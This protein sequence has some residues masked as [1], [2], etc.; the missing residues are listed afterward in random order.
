MKKRIVSIVVVAAIIA[1]FFS[2]GCSDSANLKK[3]TDLSVLCPKEARYEKTELT[4]LNGY[5][6]EYNDEYVTVFKKSETSENN[7]KTV[8]VTR[9]KAYNAVTNEI[10]DLPE[11]KVSEGDVTFIDYDVY[12]YSYAGVGD[13]NGNK[14]GAVA[15]TA[16][17]V[18]SEKGNTYSEKTFYLFDALGTLKTEFSADEY[19]KEVVY[20][21]GIT[22]NCGEMYFIVC[23]RAFRPTPNGALV[24]FSEYDSRI[25]VPQDVCY[26]AGIA[27]KYADN[28]IIVYNDDY[29]VKS[30]YNLPDTAVHSFVRFLSDG[31]A[32][33]QYFTIVGAESNDYDFV[34]DGVKYKMTTG[35]LRLD[36]NVFNKKSINFIVYEMLNGSDSSVFS[37]IRLCAD[38]VVLFYP[39]KDK[40]IYKNNPV[41][42]DMD[43][44]LNL[45]QR[46]NGFANALSVPVAVGFGR[47]VVEN[48]ADNIYAVLD[49]SGDIVASESLSRMEKVETNGRFFLIDGDIYYIKEG[50]FV[51]CEYTESGD[52]FILTENG[53]FAA[54]TTDGETKYYFITEAECRDTG[55]YL[56]KEA[57][58]L[59]YVCKENAANPLTEFDC[60][61]YKKDGAGILSFTAEYAGG[62]G[63]PFLESCKSGVYIIGYETK[64][65]VKR[66]VCSENGEKFVEADEAYLVSEGNGYALFSYRDGESKGYFAVRRGN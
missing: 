29:S 52:E 66:F 5:D 65:G 1:A 47:Y 15:V 16:Q 9:R 13:A 30:V 33:V 56:V 64:E 48:K 62:A 10:F 21:Y 34:S 14:F 61:I 38:N 51:K 31:T 12:V 11:E 45:K 63:N 25:G 17:R 57:G 49:N 7:G 23:D 28:A 18:V 36:N 39:V 50:K 54:R 2:F 42:A 60:A 58:N 6:P 43:N 19:E 8:I 24:P 20:G 32:F 44:E 27:A 46:L 59:Y 3:I 40:K 26:T 37:D 22:I 4:A 53:V 55:A 35:K 41:I